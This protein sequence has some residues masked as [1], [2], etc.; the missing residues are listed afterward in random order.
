M[1]IGD[2]IGFGLAALF[3]LVLIVLTMAWGIV[4]PVIGLLYLV[5]YL[6]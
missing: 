1:T 4:F 5:G 6:S 3:A 2:A